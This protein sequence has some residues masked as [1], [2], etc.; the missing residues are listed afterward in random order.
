ERPTG[1][2]RRPA[3]G[4]Q[5]APPRFS[6]LVAA[7]LRKNRNSR[8][9]MPHQRRGAPRWQGRLSPRDCEKSRGRKQTPTR[10]KGEIM[11]K[12]FEI[13]GVVT[14]VVLIGFGIA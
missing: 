13:G 8:P 10:R 7:A 9:G 6:R 11:R 5:R 3:L 14:A 4:R 2:R 1:G 12:L